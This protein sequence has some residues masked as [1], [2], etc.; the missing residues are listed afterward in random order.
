MALIWWEIGVIVALNA[1]ILAGTLLM[2]VKFGAPKLLSRAEV[3]MGGAIGRF[4]QSLSEQAAEEEGSEGS[5]AS[6]PGAISLGG[7][8]IDI[9][10]IK[11]LMKIAPQLIQL[12]QTFGLVKGGGGGGANPF[13]Q[14]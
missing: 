1:A 2:F 3:W 13:L 11:E 12:A 14:P 6:S 10:T 9:G 4:M 5:S 7:F 8:K